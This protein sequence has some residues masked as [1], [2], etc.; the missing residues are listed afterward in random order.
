MPATLRTDPPPILQSPPAR[1][2]ADEHRARAAAQRREQTTCDALRAL[3]A[4]ASIRFRVRPS[5][6]KPE[7]HRGRSLRVPPRLLMR[8]NARIAACWRGPRFESLSPELLAGV[9][10]SL[11]RGRMN[12]DAAILDCVL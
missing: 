9:E 2:S 7:F 8:Y 3:A 12:L 10:F 6:G 5:R 4:G 11:R 1:T